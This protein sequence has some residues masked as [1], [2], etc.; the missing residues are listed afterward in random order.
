[1]RSVLANLELIF[2]LLGLLEVGLIPSILKPGPERFWQMV[3]TASIIIMIFHG[4]VLWLVRSRQRKHR[5]AALQTI[6]NTLES[7]RYQGLSS[8]MLTVEMMEPVTDADRV[9]LKA[10]YGSANRAFETVRK[11]SGELEII[12]VEPLYDWQH[13]DFKPG[14]ESLANTPKGPVEIAEALL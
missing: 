11:I 1:M 13:P 7:I 6:Q 14:R 2:N 3:A 9:R 10:I 8:I 4:V 12:A 5:E